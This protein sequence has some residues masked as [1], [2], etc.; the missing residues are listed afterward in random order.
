M[1]VSPETSQREALDA[2]SVEFDNISA[3]WRWAVQ[4]GDYDILD[5]ALC[6]R[7]ICIAICVAGL[8]MDSHY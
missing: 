2:I 4:R 7:Y 6:I 5:L 3:A 1:S 8:R